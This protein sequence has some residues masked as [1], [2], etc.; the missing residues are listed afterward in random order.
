MPH[1]LQHDRVHRIQL[2]VR[3]DRDTPLGG[4][5]GVQMPPM[6]TSEKR[7][8]F[9]GEDWTLCRALG[10]QAKFDFARTLFWWS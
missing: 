6:L 5:D 8:I 9:A 4:V 1:V 7:N 10:L 2:R 3:D